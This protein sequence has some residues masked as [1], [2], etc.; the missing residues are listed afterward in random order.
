MCKSET[1]DSVSSEVAPCV[2]TV[3]TKPNKQS[4]VRHVKDKPRGWEGGW[5]CKV[6]DVTLRNIS[7]LSW[8]SPLL[9]EET[10]VPGEIH[11]LSQVADKLYHIMLCRNHWPSVSHWQTLWHSLYG[12]YGVYLTLCGSAYFSDEA[13]ENKNCVSSNILREKWG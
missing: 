3:Y 10:R 1:D 5:G 8:R 7:V 9:A 6:F 13:K 11:G 4:S 2:F 12:M